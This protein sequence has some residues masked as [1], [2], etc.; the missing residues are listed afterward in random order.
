[1]QVLAM[2][3]SNYVDG[4]ELRIKEL[5]A[6][7]NALV[8][9]VEQLRQAAITAHNAHSDFYE[10]QR[11]VCNAIMSTPKQCLADRDAEVAKAAYKA[12]AYVFTQPWPNRDWTIDFS[13]NEYANQLRQV[14]GGE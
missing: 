3:S 14:K 11:F 1:M 4:L 8:E 10:G 12:A 6:E 13:A 9:Q 5:T 2:I 7:R